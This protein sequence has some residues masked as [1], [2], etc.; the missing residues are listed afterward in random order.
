MSSFEPDPEPGRWYGCNPPSG[1]IFLGLI[2]ASARAEVP[3]ICP[4]Y[5]F[6]QTPRLRAVVYFSSKR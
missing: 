4:A 3:G 5:I 6:D 1:S 2:Y